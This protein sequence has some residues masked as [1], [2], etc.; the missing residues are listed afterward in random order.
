MIPIFLWNS[1]KTKNKTCFANLLIKWTACTVF[2]VSFSF[3]LILLE[4]GRGS[5]KNTTVPLK[6]LIWLLPP[7][8]MIGFI[9]KNFYW[10]F[11]KM[12][13]QQQGHGKVKSNSRNVDWHSFTKV[14]HAKQLCRSI[15]SKRPRIWI[16]LSYYHLQWKWKGTILIRINDNSPWQRVARHDG[17]KDTVS[18]RG[19]KK[20]SIQLR[21]WDTAGGLC[22]YIFVESAN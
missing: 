20:L 9:H 21:V 10:D 5:D 13:R 15:S 18:V 7:E 12:C 6:N 11:Q 8:W 14:H 3:S 22:A 4:L 19:E 2:F 16:Q 1:R 17:V